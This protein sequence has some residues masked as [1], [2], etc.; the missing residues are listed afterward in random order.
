MR[1]S[2]SL[3]ECGECTPFC[4]I[5]ECTRKR[6]KESRVTNRDPNSYIQASAQ[7]LA[8]TLASKNSDYAPTGEFS[9]FEGAAELAAVSTFEAIIVQVGIKMTRINGLV[10]SYQTPNN[11]SLQ[12]SL[13]DL[14]GYATIAHAYLEYMGKGDESIERCPHP[15]WWRTG[16]D[17]WMCSACGIQQSGEFVDD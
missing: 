16:A 14:A 1:D 8:E 9:N 17:S 13:L 5:Y 10:G 12:D 4:T 3:M 7:T 2:Y 11:E 15:E 6:S